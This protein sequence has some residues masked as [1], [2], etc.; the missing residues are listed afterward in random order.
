[1]FEVEIFKPIYIN[2]EKTNYLISNFGNVFSTINNID[3]KIHYDKDQYKTIALQ[4]NK[5]RVTKRINRLV[6]EAFIPNPNNL[7]VVNHKKGGRCE[8]GIWN[9]NPDNLE[10]ETVGGNTRHAV[11]TGLKKGLEGEDNPA[12]K[13]SNNKVKEICE[14]LMK[15]YTF[16]EISKKHNIPEATIHNFYNKRKRK[17]ITKNYNFPKLFPSSNKYSSELKSSIKSY[18]YIGFSDKKIIKRM[19]LENT[20]KIKLL[21]AGIRRNINKGSTTIERHPYIIEYIDSE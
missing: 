15:G 7:P 13:Y 11:R 19:N 2:G 1:M 8:D 12:T 6:A 14:D 9:N 20:N 4:I 17:K 18:I 3:L 16:R 21:I 5:K 10:W